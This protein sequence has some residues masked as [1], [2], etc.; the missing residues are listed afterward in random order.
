MIYLKYLTIIFLLFISS[1]SHQDQIVIINSDAPQVALD[2][3]YNKTLNLKVKDSREN[4]DFIGFRNPI[5]IWKL[6]E[7]YK[8]PDYF[9]QDLQTQPPV[10]NLG[11]NQDLAAI[12]RDKLSENLNRRGL[13][14]KRF[15]P[16][17]V[18][19]EILELSFIPATYRVAV[20]SKIRVKA[21][22]KTD[23]LEKIYEKKIVKYIPIFGV[24]NKYYNR[25]INDCLDRNIQSIISDNK[26]W[27]FLD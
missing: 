13:K 8:N 18:S 9:S 12:I 11:N 17:Q 5:N 25:I 10:I 26:L 4:G 16:N 20:Y 19:V 15:T 23:N 7:D 1:C 2:K 27:N 22:N 3:Y 6:S 24:G 21:L 14:L